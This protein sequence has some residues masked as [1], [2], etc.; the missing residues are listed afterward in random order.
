VSSSL[1]IGPPGSGKTRKILDRLEAAVRAGRGSKIRLVTPTASMARHLLHE[2]ARRNLA[3]S[4]DLALPVRRLVAELT[5]DLKEPTAAQKAWLLQRAVEQSGGDEFRQVGKTPGF[6]RRLQS[7]IEELQALRCRP[8]QLPPEV[9]AFA[10]VFRLYEGFLQA[11]GMT[12]PG[13]R[14]YQAAWA[15][16][17][18]LPGIQEIY[19]DGFFDLSPAEQDFVASLARAGVAVTVTLPAEP[20]EG[21]LHTFERR[22]LTNVERARPEPTLVAAPGVD[23]EVAEIAR[24]ILEARNNGRAFRD[25]GVIVRK[26]ETYAAPVRAIFERYGIPFR[27]QTRRILAYEEPVVWLRGLLAAVRD[28]FPGET[29]L[30]ALRRPASPVSARPEF[31]IYDLRVRERLPADG[32]DLF[33]R[34]ADDPMASYIDRLEALAAWRDKPAAPDQWAERCARLAQEHVAPP[35]VP[36][37]LEPSRVIELRAFTRARAAFA[38]AGREAAELLRLRGRLQASLAEFIDALE[39]VL[40][41]APFTVP[42]DRRNVVNVL[43]AFEARQWELPLVFVCGLVEGWFPSQ[44]AEDLFLGERVRRRLK[45]TGVALRTRAERESDEAFLFEI[46]MSRATEELVATYPEL[47]RAAAPLLRSSL[48]GDRDADATARP[49]TPSEQ[50]ADDPAAQGAQPLAAPGLQQEL[51]ARHPAF[52]PSKLQTFVRCPYE[53][54]A[55]KTLG[56]APL[57]LRS[58]LRQNPLR[59]GSLQHDVLHLWA[60]D[61]EQTI[62]EILRGKFAEQ[63]QEI[64]VPGGFRAELNL[65]VMREDLARFA[66]EPIA[67][68]LGGREEGLETSLQFGVEVD[69]RG[70]LDVNC[71]IDRFETF[72]G[73]RVLVIDYKSSGARLDQLARREETGE[74]MQG[75]LYLAGLRREHGL[76][77]GGLLFVGL[78][79]ETTIRGWVWEGLPAAAALPEKVRRVSADK[80]DEMVR[81]AEQKAAQCSDQIRSGVIEVT[82]TDP[83]HCREYCDFRDVCRVVV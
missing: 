12:S 77:P 64:A 72:D 32:L 71:R 51:T 65:T 10:E 75:A 55:G 35:S 58:T 39:A 31:E 45:R 53:F 29:T 11:H 13:E 4:G 78:R 2:L 82:P 62:T 57:P 26:P 52:S 44:P 8:D 83:K 22:R 47:D 38:E 6:L 28:G 7:S 48:L 24:R 60:Q 3:V 68:A 41:R 79:D 19:F 59:K 33:R 20:P 18:G 69:E 14:I 61:R 25:V 16:D 30:A 56:L 34:D 80:L 1:W 49:V 21:F 63:L 17:E 40:T 42:D 37:K 27:I 54:F 74:N 15:A 50:A 5:P 36:Q 46:A 67:G 76:L 23:E 43:T 9:R 70:D 73:D 66:S 81:L